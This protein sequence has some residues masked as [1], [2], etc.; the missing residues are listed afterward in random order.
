MKSG[1]AASVRGEGIERRLGTRVGRSL[2][3]PA[4]I[5][6]IAVLLVNVL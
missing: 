5:S 1:N 3:L 2:S 4:N 6:G